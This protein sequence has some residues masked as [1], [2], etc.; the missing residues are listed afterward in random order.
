MLT[1]SAGAQRRVTFHAGPFYQNGKLNE[2][3][4]HQIG[5]E[6]GA[7][8]DPIFPLPLYLETALSAAVYGDL[9]SGAG[10]YR[11]EIP[12]N[13]TW[14]WE[15]SPLFS[16]GP[17]AGVSGA[18]NWRIEGNKTFFTWGAQAGISIRP[19]FMYI[20]VGYYKDFVPYVGTTSM[21]QGIRFAL[22]VCF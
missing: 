4:C 19:S 16:V 21:Q 7:S 2:A 5:V 20:N 13:L 3:T 12:L 22:G 10:N 18:L 11:F 1:L 14:Q 9:K 6:F 17:Y 15:P 8:I